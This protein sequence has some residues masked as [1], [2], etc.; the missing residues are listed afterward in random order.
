MNENSD[1]VGTSE[2]DE[3]IRVKP[4]GKGPENVTN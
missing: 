1:E 3:F 2:V 4:N